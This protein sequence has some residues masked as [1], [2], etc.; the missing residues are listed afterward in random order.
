VSLLTGMSATAMALTVL[1]VL[2]VLLVLWAARTAWPADPPEPKRV[3]QH[4]RWVGEGATRRID[5]LAEEPPTQI[6]RDQVARGRCACLHLAHIGRC[7]A[8]ACECVS[9]EG[10]TDPGMR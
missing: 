3:A 10:F 2:A 9:P 8:V 4:G 5:R 1:F 6:I 7:R